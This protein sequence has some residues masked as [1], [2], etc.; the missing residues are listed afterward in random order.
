MRCAFDTTTYEEGDVS[1]GDQIVSGKDT[2]MYLVSMLQRDK[3]I[4]EDDSYIIKTGW[5][6]WCQAS[7]VLI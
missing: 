3:D 4:D 2:F 1:L 5:I 7:S 6:K